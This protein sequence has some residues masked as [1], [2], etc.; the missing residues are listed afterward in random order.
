MRRPL[1]LDLQGEEV[2]V[3]SEVAHKTGA[4]LPKC[5]EKRLVLRYYISMNGTLEHRKAFNPLPAL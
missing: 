4:F 5:S 3:M 1:R 2:N